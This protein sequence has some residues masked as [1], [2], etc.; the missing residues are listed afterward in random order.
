MFDSSIG[1]ESPVRMFAYT[2]FQ[3]ISHA[4][5]KEMRKKEEVSEFLG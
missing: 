5:E 1:C 3:I 2:L 4:C